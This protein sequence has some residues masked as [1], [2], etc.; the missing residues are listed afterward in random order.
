MHATEEDGARQ[1]PNAMTDQDAVLIALRRIIR[2]TDQNSKRVSR[3]TG[4]TTPQIVLLKAIAAEPGATLGRVTD[5]VSLSQATVTAIVDRLEER[6]L[7]V[8]RR[9]ARDKRVVNVELTESGA[10]LLR[11]APA[12]LQ[13]EFVRRFE[14]LP[15][16]RKRSIIEALDA[17][18]AMMNAREIDASPILTTGHM[19]EST[20]APRGDDVLLRTP[21]DTDG[22]AVHALIRICP[23]LDQN[24]LYCNLLQCLHFADTCA[25][26]ER[27]AR[28]VGFVSGYLPPGRPDTLFIWQ[29]AVHPEA[30]GTGLGKR[31]LEAILARDAC[32]DV[33]FLE[34]TVTPDNGPSTAMFAGFAKQ[35][36]A[37]LARSEL[38]TR[39]RHFQGSHE[40]EWLLRIGPFVP[41]TPATGNG[42]PPG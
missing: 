7:V 26:A 16:L 40:S 37:E 3:S 4:L 32:R 21:R 23:P 18:A 41:V 19:R 39:G 34:T 11:E 31:M 36:R 42:D 24:S 22:A 15:G 28:I 38:F 2:A 25:V 33:V 8:R 13:D 9:N 20:E 6:G 29:V 17:V 10:A 14:E 12:P 5:Q 1:R 35:R 30:R 27:D